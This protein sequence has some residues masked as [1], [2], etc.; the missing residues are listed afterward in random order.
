MVAFNKSI[1]EEFRKRL[2][3]PP[4]SAPPWTA[5]QRAFIEAVATSPSSIFGEAVAGSG[6]TTVLI[7]AARRAS[8][9]WDCKTLHGL[10]YSAWCDK[11]GKNLTVS[12]SKIGDL[13]R[14]E[15]VSS[16]EFGD[17]CRLI[18]AAKNAGLIPAAS[19]VPRGTALTPD[20]H[21]TWL[22]LMDFYDLDLEES[23]IPIAR[24]V[25]RKS[26][27]QGLRGEVDFDD[28]L[29][30]PVCFR[31]VFRKYHLVLVDEAQDLS[32]IQHEMLSRVLQR[33]GSR[34]VACG[35]RRQA[36]YG[37][38]G[39]L[40]NSV[41]EMIERFDMTLL[42][43][44]V[45]FR[46]S[47]AVVAEAQRIVPEI[48]H[49]DSA[50]QGTVTHHEHLS[51]SSLPEAILCRNTAP[52]VD[53]A[54]R[55]IAAGHPAVIA[56]RQLGRTL[57]STIRKALGI[58][59]RAKPPKVALPALRAKLDAW[60]ESQ[61]ARKPRREETLRDRQAALHA[62]ISH[63]ER[64][65]PSTDAAFVLRIIEELY[66]KDAPSATHLSTIHRAKGLEWDEVLILDPFLIPSKYATQPW[67]REQEFNLLYVAITRARRHLHFCSS[68]NIGD[69]Q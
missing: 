31:G 54:L 46:C 48:R 62:I 11:I 39:A 14:D 58:K 43:L 4:T 17:L 9:S 34:L 60:I 22:S 55:L 30:F 49:A 69:D 7:E 45:S 51:L 44:T 59:A 33:S 10:G 15:D 50:P 20:T 35:D 36:I 53:L 63:A 42:P 25:L 6:K 8:S 27:Q 38:R 18:A 13:L 3:T 68:E 40:H 56:G 57:Q 23:H 41:E 64:L 65:S 2:R 47:R 1:A 52:L 21:E 24:R 16:E 28:M 12:S 32:A 66:G 19:D 61:I 29:Y 26:I 67:Q 37:F 5:E